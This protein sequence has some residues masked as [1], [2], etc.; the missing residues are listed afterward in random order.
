MSPP[1]LGPDLPLPASPSPVTTPAV[2]Q[3]SLSLKRA[4]SSSNTAPGGTVHTS[5]SGASSTGSIPFPDDEVEAATEEG[6]RHT[7]AKLQAR[8]Y[9]TPGFALQLLDILFALRVPT[10]SAAGPLTPENLKVAKVSGSMTNAVFFVSCPSVPSIRTVLLRIYG[11]SS[12]E[13]ISRPRELHTLHILSSRYGIGPRVYG[14]FENGRVEEYFDSTALSAVQMRD[15]TISGWI[16][17]RM[18]ELHCV[19]VEAVEGTTPETRGE[20]VGW[21]IAARKNFRNWLQPARDVL[22]H[23]SVSEDYRADLDFDRFVEEWR[24][25][26]VWL[27]NWEE[28][29]GASKRVFAHN[30]TQY[31]NLLRL[32]GIKGAVLDHRQIIVVDFEYASPNS[33]AFDIANHFHEWTADYHGI[34]PHRL[35]PARYPTEHERT[36]FYKAYLTHSAPPVASLASVLMDGKAEMTQHPTVGSKREA[37]LVSKAEIQRL[38]SEVRVWSPASHGMWAVWGLVQAREDLELAAQAHAN[39]AQPEDAEFDYLGYSR[40]RI[41][42]FRREIKA[43]GL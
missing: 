19:D 33:A 21:E 39:G 20:N 22:R 24:G 27:N 13:L 10:W 1:T 18:A 28:Q 2:S 3:S 31:G 35:D 4:S 16:G 9:K 42:G 15:P 41:E 23:P 26:M 12:S 32:R 29:Y 11:P 8:K 37:G 36:N 6:L 25:Y 40:C 30:D 7:G 34:A 14:T 43:L 17:A 5:V 38:D